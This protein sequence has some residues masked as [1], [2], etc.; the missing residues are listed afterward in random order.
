MAQFLRQFAMFSIRIDF[1]LFVEQRLRFKQLNQ[2]EIHNDN[3]HE[4][5]V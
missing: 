3:T 1:Q 5:T 4:Q 2:V